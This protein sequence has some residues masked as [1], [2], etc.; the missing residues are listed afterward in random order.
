MEGLTDNRALSSSQF[1]ADD[2][3]SDLTLTDLG[4]D[5]MDADTL[6]RAQQG[7][8]WARL[9]DAFERV[10]YLR[11]PTALSGV[12]DAASESESRTYP[13]PVYTDSEATTRAHE[14]VADAWGAASYAEMDVSRVFILS[15]ITGGYANA[16]V[17]VPVNQSQGTL[18]RTRT[19]LIDFR[20]TSNE[21]L[22]LPVMSASIKFW[23]AST[24]PGGINIDS[25][26]ASIATSQGTVSDGTDFDYYGEEF[27]VFD[28]EETT[29]FYFPAESIP[30]GAATYSFG[31][32]FALTKVG[33]PPP[34]IVY[35]IN[36][37]AS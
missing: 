6:T 26:K 24:M 37:D 23:K 22:D 3:E 19:V 29:P 32:F 13:S 15:Q 5:G 8:V 27:T 2:Y 36:G 28:L 34:R 10:R 14:A 35:D 16:G 31:Y 9:R 1:V 20:G 18:E 11:R 21:M 12:H 7:A 25:P 17:Y 33:Q 30:E 4:L